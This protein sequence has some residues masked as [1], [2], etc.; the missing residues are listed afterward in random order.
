MRGFTPDGYCSEG[1]G[2][3]NYGFGHYVML[4]ETLRQATGGK[5][6]LMDAAA[7]PARS[8]RSG[9]GW[10]S[11]PGIYPAFA[12]CDPGERPDPMLA[13]LSRR[14]GWGLGT[15]ENERAGLWNAASDAY[16]FALGL[17]DFPNSAAAAR[18]ATAPKAR[19]SAAA[20][21][22]RRRRHA[23]S[24]GPRR[25]RDTPWAPP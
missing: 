7:R 6:D 14:Y 1:V 20:R 24:A 17:L 15:V 4:A 5:V 19:R 9:G 16:L 22:V 10:K 2:Y 23:R 18:H 13:F 3:W 11:L 25:K 12:D 21:L 8:P